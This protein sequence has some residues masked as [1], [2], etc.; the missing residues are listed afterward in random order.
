MTIR[1]AE[2]FSRFFDPRR[3]DAQ[4][5]V[6]QGYD[7]PLGWPEPSWGKWQVRDVDV[8]SAH[9]LPSH[10]SGYCYG[11]RDVCRQGRLCAVGHFDPSEKL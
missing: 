4:Q 10:S 6:S 5:Q 2:K 3:K 1:V 9:K 7:M 8:I 11:K